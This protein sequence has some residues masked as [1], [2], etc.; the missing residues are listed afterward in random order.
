MATTAKVKMQQ[1]VDHWEGLLRATGGALVPTKCFWYLMDF[2]RKNDK[3]Q[4]ITKTQLPG[5]IT[6]KDDLQH[7]VVIPHLEAHKAQ[8]MLGV[9][10]V[11]D[12][13]WETEANYLLSVMAFWKVHIAA[14]RLNHKD[15]TFSLKN[16]VLQKLVYPLQPQHSPINNVTR[17]WLHSSNKACQK[18]VWFR[19]ILEL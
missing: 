15:V 4:Y 6:I 7:W 14:S 17:S 12:G 8:W 13:N 16:V 9:Q 5:E 11:P 2:Q 3:W 19:C 10:L 1:M 18:L